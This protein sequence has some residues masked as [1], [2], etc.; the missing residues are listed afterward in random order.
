[1]T[2]ASAI[3]ALQEAGSKLSR[4]MIKASYRA[5]TQ[6]C[7]LCVELIRQ[8]YD[9]P[10]QFRILG[11]R[12]AMEFI[13]YSNAGIRPQEQ[14]QAF[15][16]ELGYRLPVFDIKIRSQKSSPFSKL[17]QNEMAKEFF[18]MGFFRPDMADQAL[19]CMEMMDF[20]GKD[21]VM[22][23]VAQNGTLYQMVQQLQQQ[24]IQLA[25]IVDA[26]NGTAIAPGAAA[27]DL[28]KVAAPKEG[29]GTA[30]ETNPLGAAVQSSRNTDAATARSRAMNAARPQ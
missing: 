14:G 6:V 16:V 22:N 28:G 17:S 21:A 18:G 12:G 30:V 13:Q 25:A 1:M 2:A 10:R 4:D 23:R 3:A 27:A 15:G 8:F 20:E 29:S 24:V 7:T 19:S 26:Q 9:E 5:F 11:E